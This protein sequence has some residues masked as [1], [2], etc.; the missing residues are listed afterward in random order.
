MRGRW[1]FPAAVLISLALHLLVADSLPSWWTAPAREI[2]FPLEAHLVIHEKPTPRIEPSIVVPRHKPAASPPPA[3]AAEAGVSPGPTTAREE[4]P[5]QPAAA[6]EVAA[7]PDTAPSP[8][9]EAAPV[10]V[11]VAEATPRVE[12]MAMAAAA[13]ASAEPPEAARRVDLRTLPQR[14][15][16]V[17][18][19]RYGGESGMDLGRATYTWR[20]NGDRYSLSSVAEATGIAALFVSGRIE[21]RSDGRIGPTG[22]MPDEFS[23][24]RGQKRPEKASFDWQTKRLTMSKGED[25]LPDNAQDLLSFP[26]PLAMTVQG[27]ASGC[28]LPVT[29]GR[30]LRSYQFVIVGQGN[31][32]VGKERLNAVHIRGTRAGDGNLDVWLV[33]DRHWLP[34]RIRTED[35]DG[36]A[37]ELSLTHLEI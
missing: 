28:H 20:A 21:Q 29:N 37:T 7:A 19:V 9:P 34:V 1:I 15:V 33:P 11:Q 2:P 35:Q 30:R 23:M 18:N 27:G 3:I 5:P 6:S 32:Q 16:L 24:V 13:P 17:Y 26:F 36:K 22:L 12:P 4:A 31:T 25:P 14:V 10:P 8:A